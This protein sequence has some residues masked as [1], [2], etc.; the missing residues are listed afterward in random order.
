MQKGVSRTG[1]DGTWNNTRG[2]APLAFMTVF[3]FRH[4]TRV[5]V[6]DNVP[7]TVTVPRGV[8]VAFGEGVMGLHALQ[9]YLDFDVPHLSS[10]VLNAGNWHAWAHAT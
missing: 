1:E 6:A 8:G 10:V 7:H 5:F 3:N 2:A 9:S 4:G